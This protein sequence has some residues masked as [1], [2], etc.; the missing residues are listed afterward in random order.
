MI[1]SK[2]E[3]DHLAGLLITEDQNSSLCDEKW[4][5]SSKIVLKME[6]FMF[7]SWNRLQ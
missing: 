5:E 6:S 7:D 1:P 4:T 2:K 3:R